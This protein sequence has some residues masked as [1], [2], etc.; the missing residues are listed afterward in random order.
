[1]PVIPTNRLTPS[2]PP[3][4]RVSAALPPTPTS[5]PASALTPPIPGT[6]SNDGADPTVCAAPETMKGRALLTLDL[7]ECHAIGREPEHAATLA[8]T[9]L[10]MASE[11]IVHPVVTR[12]AAVRHALRQWETAPAVRELGEQLG[13]IT[14][15]EG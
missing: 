4:S 15:G 11:G 10:D 3:R 8:S 14:Q 6:A 9:A 13:E 5:V 1:M 12:A 2:R 7:A